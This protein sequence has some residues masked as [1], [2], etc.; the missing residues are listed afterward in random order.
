[1][2]VN[3]IS[4]SYGGKPGHSKKTKKKKWQL[5]EA[6]KRTSARGGEGV[7]KKGILYV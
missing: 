2:V 4:G 3:K 1:M 5:L 7:Y 6:E